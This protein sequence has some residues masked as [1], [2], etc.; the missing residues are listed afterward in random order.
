MAL[1]KSLVSSGNN[2]GR[3][4]LARRIAL[5]RHASR[6]ERGPFHDRYPV[7]RVVSL[8]PSSVIALRYEEADVDSAL[9]RFFFCPGSHDKFTRLPAFALERGCA[10]GYHQGWV[11]DVSGLG[12]RRP[13][14]HQT[15][16]VACIAR[17]SL[18][19]E[20]WQ[21]S[22]ASWPAALLPRFGS[23]SPRAWRPLGRYA[24][25]AVASFAR[26]ARPRG[27]N[28]YG[29]S[30]DRSSRPNR[31]RDTS[32]RLVRTLAGSNEL[33]WSEELTRTAYFW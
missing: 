30:I 1:H 6:R 13:A 7:C 33:C 18:A 26:P 10:T 27:K 15:G 20:A 16:L 17:R 19:S 25:R 5:H 32:P 24:G 22:T 2:F 21:R 11:V 14:G 3:Q 4:L 8:N 9:R 23:G 29:N 28:G 31:R 12:H